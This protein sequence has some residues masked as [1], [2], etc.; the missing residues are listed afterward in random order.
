MLYAI[1]QNVQ[2]FDYLLL[3][4]DK[5]FTSLLAH[6]KRTKYFE[7]SKNGKCH[8]DFPKISPFFFAISLYNANTK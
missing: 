4:S 1:C 3:L 5:K 2:V 7:N 6:Q 8:S